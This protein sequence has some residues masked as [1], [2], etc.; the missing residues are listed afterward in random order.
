M[1]QSLRRPSRYPA[2][3]G[4][5]HLVLSRTV[6]GHWL[7]AVGLN[8]RTARVSGVPADAVVVGAY[9]A[10]GVLAAAGSVLYTAR[11]E[12]GSPVLGQRLLLD[13]VGAVVIGGTSLSGG[14]GRVS[15]TLSGVL[16]LVVL[17][18]ALNLLGF[19]H[20]AIM[21]AKGGVILAAAF[22]DTARNRWLAP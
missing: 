4:V 15:W 9:V 16:F 12:T 8:P 7:R 13:V 2:V 11:L 5:T 6:F 1:K 20:F 3:A 17:D 18:N 21:M 14:K 10:S 19:S 22:L